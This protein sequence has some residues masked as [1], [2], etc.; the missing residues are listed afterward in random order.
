MPAFLTHY[1]CGIEG[2]R[3]LKKGAV[4]CAIRDHK[5]VYST[6]LAGPDLFFYSLYEMVRPGSMAAGRIM[7][8]F[9]TG[10]FLQTLYRNAVSLKGDEKETA[11][12]YLAGFLGHYCLDSQTH[13]LVY[14]I[15]ADPLEPRELGRHFRYEAA[16]DGMCCRAVLGRDITQS[17][18]LGLIR[19][20]RREKTCMAHLLS[21]TMTQVYPEILTEGKA[22][23][24]PRRFKAIL[25]E[26]FLITGLLID[27]TGF[28]E[29][30]V[31]HAEKVYP[32]Y[33]HMSPLCINANK[34]GLT[35]KEWDRFRKYFDRGVRMLDTLLPM[36]EDSVLD[37]AYEPQ[38]FRRLGSW[39]YHG[40]W[41]H[42]SVSD[43]PL[44]TLIK[45][46]KDRFDP[47]VEGTEV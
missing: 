6:G 29:F 31:F 20:S 8:K 38:F 14:S 3:H 30:L 26:Y 41:H 27:P 4:K 43:L 9:R 40:F 21:D 15:T 34:Y 18:Q 44:Q 10:A 45:N 7:H 46:T 2:Y 23:L 37:P 5:S 42:E 47:A 1:A 33:P 17:H 32:G 35:W 25:N 36:L 13:K 24:H 22:L 28:K 12:A 11:L 16:I 39:S 19:L